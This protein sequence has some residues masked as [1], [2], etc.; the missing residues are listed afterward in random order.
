MNSLSSHVSV[1]MGWS[2]K[3]C[4]PL[5]VLCVF[6]QCGSEEAPK[7]QLIIQGVPGV[8]DVNVPE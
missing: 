3:G 5:E 6:P 4:V 1:S 8:L 2:G 7:D